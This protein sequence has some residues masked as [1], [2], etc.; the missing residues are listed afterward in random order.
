MGRAGRGHK[1]FTFLRA[2]SLVG[3]GIFYYIYLRYVRI[4]MRGSA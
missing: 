2:Q 4:L 3:L 1:I